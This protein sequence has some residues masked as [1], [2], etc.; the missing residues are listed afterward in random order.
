MVRLYPSAWTDGSSTRRGT[1]M[2]RPCSI[3]TVRT[4]WPALTRVAVARITRLTR[5]HRF[6]TYATPS[7]AIR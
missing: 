5:R 1:K 4:G 2:V 7:P 3:R 6:L